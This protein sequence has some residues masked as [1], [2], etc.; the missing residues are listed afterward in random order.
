M[1]S[2]RVAI[3]TTHPETVLEDYQR[4]ADLAGLREALDPGATTILKDNISWHFPF[5][6]ANTTPWQLEG[7]I[8]A[9]RA[10]GFRDLACVQNRTVVTNAFKGTDLNGYWPICEA[11][12]VPVLFNFRPADMRWI[13]F[14]PKRKMLVLDRIFDGR[15]RI[16]DYFQGKNVVHLP[17]AKCVA[18]DTEIVLA[19]GLL[20]TIRELVEQQM[21]EAPSVAG[22]ADGDHR[23]AGTV[24][25]LAM[26]PSGEIRPFEASWFWRTSARERRMLRLRTRTG[27]TLTAT[28]EH[29]IWTPEGWAPL[30]SLSVGRRVA[31]ARSLRVAGAPQP[32]PRTFAAPEPSRI[33]GRDGR[34]HTATFSQQVIDAY[35]A[36]TPATAIAERSGIRWQSI[37]A[38]LRR[39]GVPIRRNLAQLRVPERTSPGFWR[40]M[41]YLMAEGCIEHA[42]CSDKLWWANS[43][44]AL[45]EDFAE[46][47]RAL[48]GLEA[49]AHANRK[50]IYVYSRNLGR[51]LAELGLP[52]PLNAG[53]KRVPDLLFRCTEAE[54]SAFLSAYLDGDGTVSKKQAELKATTKSPQLAHDLQVLFG[55]LGAVALCRPVQSTIP[56]K[57]DAPRTYYLVTVSGEGLAR[58]APKLQLRHPEK[59]RR[60]AEQAQ[61]FRAGK[62]PSNWD[63]VPLPTAMFR[64]VR[65]G[66]GLSY[67]ATG[68]PSSVESIEQGY[69]HP[70]PRV[71]RYFVDLFRQRDVED[72]FAAEISHL[73]TISSQDLAWDI[74][75]QIEDADDQHIELFD[76][77]VPG[78]ECFIGNG[79][80]L[81][82]CHIY[83][84][85]TGAMKNAFGGLLNERRHYTH[86]WIH[87]TLTDLLAIQKE[88]HAGLFAMVDGTTAGNGAGP[89]IMDPQTKNVILASAD[90]VAIDAVA[91]KL[92]G[93]DPLSIRYIR[94]AHEAGLGVGDPR[95]VEIVGDAAAADQ[96][97][98]FQVGKTFLSFLGWLSWYGPTRRLQRLIFRTPLA[99]LTYPVSEIY[100]DYYRWP[101]RER[102]V[103]ERWRAE[104]PWGR[105]FATYAERGHLAGPSATGESAP[106]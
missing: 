5:P 65:Q 62:Q 86:T 7:S 9:L 45:R 71:A 20:V 48:F 3:L 82:N 23:V 52:V 14:Q 50:H 67:A 97:W 31:V 56:G 85:T 47:T 59:A 12:G 101:F 81:H 78:A 1:A 88:I 84:T 36:G 18:G 33:D 21:A 15:I 49:R 79:L 32:L 22:D 4:L 100:H 102:R 93:F 91:A 11:H 25:L 29:L 26:S 66:L 77:T 70:T 37:T 69:T 34:V 19:D 51:F 75:E 6:A 73:C 94:L 16:P 60:L 87:E 10:A 105:L 24:E 99:N 68:K 39:H 27:R 83:T 90:Q 35:Q 44:S 58:L 104:S 28:A 41:G 76:L 89:R 63:V 53:N 54:I 61:R 72:R 106:A 57:W 38:I 43:Q 95:Q 92:M 98:H 17:T 103:F 80:V 30:G 40:W 74:V 42:K 13:E 55:R 46:L 96:N 8:L 2:A 64:S